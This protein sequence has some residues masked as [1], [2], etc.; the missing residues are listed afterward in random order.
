[1]KR[2]SP[3]H[4]AV[5]HYQ[6]NHNATGDTLA[7]RT[8]AVRH[9]RGLIGSRRT[10]RNNAMIGSGVIILAAFISHLPTQL[11]VLAIG[12]AIFVPSFNKLWGG[13]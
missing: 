10:Y 4:P 9:R 8:A 5:R 13:K 2:Y 3:N 12:A 1:M 7:E 11:T 6:Q